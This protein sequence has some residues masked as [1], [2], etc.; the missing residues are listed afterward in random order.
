MTEV[1]KESLDIAPETPCFYVVVK[2]SIEHFTEELTKQHMKNLAREYAHAVSGQVMTEKSIITYEVT[3]VSDVL[4]L[5]AD[6]E[7]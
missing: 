2:V 7:T 6:D 3:P 1:E 4:W 5:K